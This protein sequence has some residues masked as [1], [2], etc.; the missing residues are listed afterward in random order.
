MRT[1]GTTLPEP[2][3]WYYVHGHFPTD[4]C[5]IL[6]FIVKCKPESCKADPHDKAQSQPN[7]GDEHGRLSAV[8]VGPRADEEADNDAGDGGEDG[9]VHSHGGDKLLDFN[10]LILMGAQVG[11]DGRGVVEVVVACQIDDKVLLTKLI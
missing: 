3:T 2:H 4:N 11:A 5:D 1:E 9:L 7:H 8:G 10:L 6:V